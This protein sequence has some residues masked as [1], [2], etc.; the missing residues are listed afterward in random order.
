MRPGARA[1]AEHRPPGP[2]SPEATEAAILPKLSQPAPPVTLIGN[3]DGILTRCVLAFT[4]DG[5]ALAPQ[6]RRELSWAPGDVRDG[7]ALAWGFPLHEA[8]AGPPARPFQCCR[9][10]YRPVL[11]LR[12]P[13]DRCT[14]IGIDWHGNLRAPFL[15]SRL[16]LNPV[17]R[18]MTV[19]HAAPQ[20]ISLLVGEF[21]ARL[22]G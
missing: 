12:G 7:C 17:C 2:P 14:Q 6:P 22:W 3:R 5:P 10:S 1:S 11:S 15:L 20:R 13:L 4:R 21:V 19:R 16:I 8:S 18:D 9:G